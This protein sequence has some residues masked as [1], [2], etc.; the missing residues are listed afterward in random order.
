MELGKIYR[1]VSVNEFSVKRDDGFF[2][3]S[4]EFNCSGELVGARCQEFVIHIIS[5]KY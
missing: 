4:F 3:V 2:S 1:G 5:V